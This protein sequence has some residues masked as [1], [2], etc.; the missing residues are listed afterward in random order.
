MCTAS[1]VDSTG[2]SP[3]LVSPLYLISRHFLDAAMLL[4]TRLTNSEVFPENIGPMIISMLPSCGS[5][6]ATLWACRRDL[7]ETDIVRVDVVKSPGAH[8]TERLRLRGSRSLR[9]PIFCTQIQAAFTQIHPHVKD[10][11]RRLSYR[12]LYCAH[13]LCCTCRIAA[14]HSDQ[15]V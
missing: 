15:L 3:Y 10:V 6:A 1:W 14:M 12:W 5:L 8:R 2:S 4:R 13:I 9:L 7:E 11:A